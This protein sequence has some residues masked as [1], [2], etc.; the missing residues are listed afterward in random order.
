MAACIGTR[1]VM[2]AWPPSQGEALHTSTFLGNPT[3]CAAALASLAVIEEEGLVERSAKLGREMLDRLRTELASHPWVAEVR[4]LGMMIG[5]EL[6]RDRAGWAPDGALALLVM[7][8]AL[9]RGVLVLPGGVEGNV[10][11]L[12]PPLNI[13]RD[14]L[15]HALAVLVDTLETQGRS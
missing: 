6:V 8:E 13:A 10:I 9:R 15:D 2:E 7:K 4:G 5:V 11:S 14:Q 1:E 3:V 12:S